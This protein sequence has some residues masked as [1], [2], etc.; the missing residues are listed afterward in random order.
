MYLVR[1]RLEAM[2]LNSGDKNSKEQ[3]LVP[4]ALSLTI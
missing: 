2:K 1:E 4:I 3:G